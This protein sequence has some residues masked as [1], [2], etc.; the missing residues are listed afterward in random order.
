MGNNLLDAQETELQQEQSY[1]IIK[2]SAVMNNKSKEID[3]FIILMQDKD[4]EHGS[5]KKLLMKEQN[6][7]KYE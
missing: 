3:C 2:A 6:I 1:K 7:L 4:I 5:V